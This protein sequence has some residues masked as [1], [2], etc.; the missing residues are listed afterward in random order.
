M[1][2]GAIA[3]RVAMW[4]RERELETILRKLSQHRVKQL[5]AFLADLDAEAKVGARSIERGIEALLVELAA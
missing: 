2:I 5:L 4:G 1:A 3:P